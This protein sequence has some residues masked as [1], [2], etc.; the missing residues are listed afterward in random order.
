[1]AA[2]SYSLSLAATTGECWVEATNT[3]TGSVLFTAT[4]FSGQSHTVVATGPVTVIAGAPAA[5]SA[6]VNGTAVTLPSGYQAPFTLS[7]QTAA[8]SA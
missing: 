4:L 8:A 6:T 1:V 2:T 7:F 3:A 5:F